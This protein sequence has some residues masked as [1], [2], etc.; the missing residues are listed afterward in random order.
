VE[1]KN[2]RKK[3]KEKKQSRR[4]EMEHDFKMDSIDLYS[5]H[6]NWIA[7]CVASTF[8]ILTAMKMSIVV[9]QIVTPRGIAGG[10]QRFG[11]T[12]VNTRLQDVITQKNTLHIVYFSS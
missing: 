1:R 12:L 6:V 11:G 4:T 9:F 2:V 5:D 10:Y 8:E 3:I 7:G